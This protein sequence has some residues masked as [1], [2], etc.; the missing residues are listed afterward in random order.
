MKEST[1]RR[2]IEEIDEEI[3]RSERHEPSNFIAL[4]DVPTSRYADRKFWDI[5][6]EHLWTNTWLF[7]GHVDEV[8]ETG[9]Y[10]LWDESG[11]PIVIVRGNDRRIRAYLNV[12]QHRG[13]PLVVSTKGKISAFSC[14]F[15]GW[16]YDLTGTLRFIPDE[17][18][19]PGLDKSE[20]SLKPLRCELWGNFIFV[21][22]NNDATPLLEWLGPL[23]RDLEDFG[24]EQRYIVATI[25]YELGCNWKAG[26][27]SNIESYHLPTVHPK[28]VSTFLDH[29]SLI[30]LYR[31]GHSRQ[32]V[33][34]D[35][36]AAGKQ[37]N[38]ALDY[39]T[40]SYGQVLTGRA[41]R[42]FVLSPNLLIAADELQ[43]PIFAYWPKG[44]DK[45]RMVVYYTT[46]SADDDAN[47]D[48]CTEMIRSFDAVLEEDRV[49]LRATQQA[50]E[51]KTIKAIKFGTAERRLYH[52][53]EEIDRVIE[54]CNIPEADRIK[55]MTAP[56]I[57]EDPYPE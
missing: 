25:E 50:Y 38:F 27:G 40:R 33:P 1:A 8:P 3:M 41:L 56:Y 34:Y 21:N 57:N 32:F 49:S 5:E 54:I 30:H 14:K 10:K 55:P 44:I 23:R 47:S 53:E 52:L 26:I 16:T 6:Q 35:K 12:C 51:N 28:T 9:S 29:H 13:G 48:A 7:A 20:R 24:F 45:T 19:F 22:R 11:V 17:Q 18:D 4:P 2:V 39:S 36:K 43:F 31:N 15:H 37:G 42:N 46:T